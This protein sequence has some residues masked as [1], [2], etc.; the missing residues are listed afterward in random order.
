MIDTGEIFVL[1][2]QFYL[3]NFLFLLFCV[4]PPLSRLYEKQV[5]QQQQQE[6][7]KNIRKNMNY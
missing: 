6:G 4:L 3:S 2:L 5:Q 7:E 1:P